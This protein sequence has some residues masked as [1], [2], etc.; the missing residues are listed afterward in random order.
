MH[1][2]SSIFSKIDQFSD[3]VGNLNVK[4]RALR[5]RIVQNKLRTKN[6]SMVFVRFG[7]YSTPIM[8]HILARYTCVYW[9]A[10]FKDRRVLIGNV[11]F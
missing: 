5:P 10:S 1:M 9:Y 8:T 6:E 2:F 4:N 3:R 7:Y 11:N